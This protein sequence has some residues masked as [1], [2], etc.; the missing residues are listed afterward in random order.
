MPAGK[1][2]KK[3]SAANSVYQMGPGLKMDHG[4]KQ[5][6]NPGLHKKYGM[7][8][9]SAKTQRADDLKYMPVD[10]RAGTKQMKTG[11]YQDRMNG[12]LPE[13]PALKQYGMDKDAV[14]QVGKHMAAPQMEGLKKKAAAGPIGDKIISAFRNLFN[15]KD[16]IPSNPYDAE[17]KLYGTRGT[18]AD[19]FVTLDEEKRGGKGMRRRSGQRIDVKPIAGKND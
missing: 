3:G 15:K 14:K 2:V 16:G 4:A 10:D 1:L 18:G 11:I 8:Q 19:A 5:I 13:N 7:H 12:K 9:E 6:G 17:E